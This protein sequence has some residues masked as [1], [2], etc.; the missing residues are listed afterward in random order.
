MN[1][2]SYRCTEDNGLSFELLVDGQ[3]LGNLVRWRLGDPILG[4]SKRPPAL[5]ASWDKS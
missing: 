2:L 4:H 1:T 5:A 3:P